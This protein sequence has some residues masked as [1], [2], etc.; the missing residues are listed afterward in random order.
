MSH[1]AYCP[2]MEG[3][4]LEFN[5]DGSIRTCGH[6]NTIIGK[7]YDLSTVLNSG[8]QYMQLINSRL[9][10]NNE[11]CIGC[12]IEGACAGQCHVTIESTERDSKLMGNMC[13]LMKQAT[14]ELI[15]DYMYALPQM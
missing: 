1:H 15:K 8:S 7:N 11:M 10:G 2:A 6:T 4:T 9:P 13:A 5:V 14:Q 12:E 3:T